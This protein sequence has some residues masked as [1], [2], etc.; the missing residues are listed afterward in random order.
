MISFI[1]ATHVTKA[2]EP[3]DR[4]TVC[5]GDLCQEPIYQANG[6]FLPLGGAT[7]DPHR[8][9]KNDVA[10]K[11]T[12]NPDVWRITVTYWAPPSTDNK[13]GSVWI[14]YPTQVEVLA[15]YAG[16]G[17]GD[18]VSPAGLAS[19]TSP[20]PKNRAS[21]CAIEQRAYGRTLAHLELCCPTLAASIAKSRAR[22]MSRSASF[23]RNTCDALLQEVEPGNA[24]PTE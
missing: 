1:K 9:Y 5:N 18:R 24:Q 8:G 21:G 2:Y 15:E 23:E 11:P 3:Y 19:A 20:I 7:I 22:S 4:V 12:E 13:L 10:W 17:S 14:G 6:L 16:G